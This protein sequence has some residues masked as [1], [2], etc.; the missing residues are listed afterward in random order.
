VDI[1]E[2]DVKASKAKLKADQAKQERQRH[3]GNTNSGGMGD[4]PGGFG[5]GGAAGDGVGGEAAAAMA[6]RKEEARVKAEEAR[7]QRKAIHDLEQRHPDQFAVLLE[8]RETAA[9]GPS[10][11]PH[12]YARIRYIQKERSAEAAEESAAFVQRLIEATG[13]GKQAAERAVASVGPRRPHESEAARLQS[14]VELVREAEAALALREEMARLTPEEREAR[15]LAKIEEKREAENKRR[16]RK[17]YI[18]SLP[19]WDREAAALRLDREDEAMRAYE[20]GRGPKP[21]TREE[22]VAATVAATFAGGGG[23]GGGGGSGGDDE[24]AG[25]RRR[26][27]F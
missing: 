21:K 6:A 8:S 18:E 11:N 7:R 1:G 24:A 20:E 4:G 27:R 23:G 5:Y 12:Q 25:C 16:G 10:L 15:R 13:C 22:E 17:A 2:I 19:H 9:T 3:S 14:A 26:G